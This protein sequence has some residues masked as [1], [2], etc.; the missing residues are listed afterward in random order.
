MGC[1]MF[2]E[3]AIFRCISSTYSCITN[4]VLVT[5]LDDISIHIWVWPSDLL[6][7]NM[8]KGRHLR[9]KRDYVG[10]IPKRRTP[11]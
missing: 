6:Q 5:H 9:E 4:T 10:K 8:G 2:S 7:K 3:S 1:F 11:P